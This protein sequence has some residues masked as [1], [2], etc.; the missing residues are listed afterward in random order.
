M[1]AITAKMLLKMENII[2][3]DSKL[4]ISPILIRQ[5]IAVSKQSTYIMFDWGWSSPFNAYYTSIYSLPEHKIVRT[6][7]RHI[8][9][10]AWYRKYFK[11]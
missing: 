2:D 9:E 4:R 1:D 10:K 6:N 11:E 8:I 3:I 5:V 7:T